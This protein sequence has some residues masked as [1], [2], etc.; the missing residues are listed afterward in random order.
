MKNHLSL[1]RVA[2]AAL[3][4]GTATLT[5]TFAQSTPP[6]ATCTHCPHNSVLTDAEQAQLKQAYQAALA[7]NPSLQTEED[8]LKQQH[9]TLKSEGSNATADDKKAL[10]QQWHDFFTN[11]KTAELN[12]DPTLGPIFAKLEAAHQGWHH[13]SDSTPGSN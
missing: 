2:L 8:S 5:A 9:E 7:A 11:L 1:T 10:H 6:S 13:H 4:L 3:A 12:I